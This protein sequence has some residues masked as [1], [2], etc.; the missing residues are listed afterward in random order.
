MTH[1]ALIQYNKSGYKFE[2]YD[3]ELKKV[4]SCST[5]DGVKNNL[6]WNKEQRYIGYTTQNIVIIEDLNQEKT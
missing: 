1:E 2:Q 6:V 5:D 3:I 4:L